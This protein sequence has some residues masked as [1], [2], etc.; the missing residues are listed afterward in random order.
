MHIFRH[1]ILIFITRSYKYVLYLRSLWKLALE[2]VEQ[3]NVNIITS[4]VMELVFSE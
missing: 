1:V 4:V 3:A 2:K